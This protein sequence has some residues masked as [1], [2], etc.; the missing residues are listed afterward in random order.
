MDTALNWRPHDTNVR[1]E[2][3]RTLFRMG[4]TDLAEL[5]YKEW[6]RDDPESD[7]W[8]TLAREFGL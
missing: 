7:Y 3:V 2:Y 4:K 5:K 1:A 6:S 8:K